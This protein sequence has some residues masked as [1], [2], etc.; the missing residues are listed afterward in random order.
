MFH[1]YHQVGVK[2]YNYSKDTIEEI[3]ECCLDISIELK[4]FGFD[5]NQN[6]FIVHE[7]NNIIIEKFSFKFE[8]NKL[9][10][11]NESEK[12]NVSC[13]LYNYRNL[14]SKMN[15]LEKISKNKIVSEEKNE[16]K[17]ISEE[18]LPEASPPEVN[19]INNLIN[20]TQ[21]LTNNVTETNELI[22]KKVKE[23]YEINKKKKKILSDENIKKEIAE[24][25]E[26]IYRADLK[27]Y[28]I[29]KKNVNEIPELFL[30]KYIVLK[31]M[32]SQN[33][34][35]VDIYWE[36]LY[37]EQEN[38]RSSVSHYNK[39]ESFSKD[40]KKD[41]DVN[42]SSELGNEMDEKYNE[43]TDDETDDEIYEDIT[44][45][46]YEWHNDTKKN[47]KKC[48][49]PQPN[50]DEINND[51]NKTTETNK[52]ISQNEILFDQVKKELFDIEEISRNNELQK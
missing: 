27:L 29:F 20:K 43:V 32:K 3:L 14:W 1:I 15:I 44:D 18:H 49:I 36:L 33:I 51:E 46:W 22:E 41:N 39:V 45:Q 31:N 12:K 19:E 48:D 11:I 8:N 30:T 23:L 16:Q 13:Y 35:D 4:N 52:N 10:F 24:E 50:Q 9:C 28:D 25:H 7:I 47:E 26:K 37:S 6:I 5:E 40:E 2:L 42:I 38:E 17:N 34:D 21:E